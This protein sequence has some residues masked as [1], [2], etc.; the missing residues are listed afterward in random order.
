MSRFGLGSV[1]LT[2]GSNTTNLLFLTLVETFFHNEVFVNFSLIFLIYFLPFLGMYLISVE[3]GIKPYLC[4]LISLFYV[5]N[6]F[7]IHFLSGLNQWNVFSLALI[8]V[9]FWIVLRYYH[10]N[11]KLFLYFGSFSAL[12]SF[13]YTNHPLNATI[14]ISTIFAVFI[15]SYYRKKSF[16]FSEIVKKYL[17]VFSA[18]LLFNC[19]WLLNMLKGV[20]TALSVYKSDLATDW[21]FS[22]IS[23]VGNPLAKSLSL[24][25]LAGSEGESFLGDY[26]NTPF[27]FFAGLIPISLVVFGIFF[28]RKES[29]N[30][31]LIHIAILMLLTIFLLKGSAPP[32]GSIYLFLFKNVPFFNIFKTPVEKFGLLYTF[33]LSILLIFTLLA[34]KDPAHSRIGIIAF[35]GY[36]LFCM[37]PLLMGEMI[38]EI[39]FGNAGTL[40]RKYKEKPSYTSF[41]RHINNERLEYKILSLPGMGNYQILFDTSQGKKYS[42]IDPLL[43]NTNKGILTPHFDSEIKAFYGYMLNKTTHNLFGSFNIGKLVIN[44]DLQP[45]YGRVGTSNARELRSQYKNL[46][47]KN[48]GNISAHTLS[49]NF[50]PV[51][52]TAQNIILCK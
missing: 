23:T 46:P 36:L 52:H 26:F 41:R 32:F 31:L 3:L 34:V 35:T 4:G 11:L 49:K 33:L 39:S 5:I 29:L 14:N 20:H 17:L 44:G 6:P 19:W 50:V 12:F 1:N 28:S 51:V 10:D 22:T 27:A 47:S 13:A 15:T 30:K 2:P 9:L 24:T 7:S 38:P 21:L 40:S 37:G 43:H 45:W 25:H 18:F 8:P 48:F 42:G 16:F